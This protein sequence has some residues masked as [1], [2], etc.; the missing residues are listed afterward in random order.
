MAVLK[1]KELSKRFG[2]ITAC[3]RVSFTLETN[4]IVGLVGENGAGKSTLIKLISGVLKKDEGRIL[5][6]EEEVEFRSPRDALRKGISTVYQDFSLVETLTIKDNIQ[7]QTGAPISEIERMLR[8]LE[9][10]L[11]L[12]DEVSEVSE[13]ERQK[14]E[15]LKALLSKPK[16]LLLDEPTHSLRKR[17]IKSLFNYLRRTKKRM[18]VLFI[19]HKL[20]E[21]REIADRALL[22]KNGRIFEAGVEEIDRARPSVSRKK[23][24][25]ELLRVEFEDFNLCLKEGEIVALVNFPPR[26]KMSA[27]SL[28]EKAVI[29]P[30][31]RKNYL[32]MELSVRKNFSIGFK[33]LKGLFLSKIDENALKTEVKEA[34]KEYD[35]KAK[36]DDVIEVLS[37]GNQQ[38]VMLSKALS[39]EFKLFIGYNIFSS[40]DSKSVGKVKRKLLRKVEDGRGI[41][42]FTEDLDEVKDIASRIFIHEKGEITCLA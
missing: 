10:S 41:L 12:N 2:D 33:K 4:E 23:G 39:R 9:F 20:R 29:V 13:N 8:E 6:D 18:G 40:L 19:S 34:I 27:L 24:K 32:F 17:E 22:M 7:L 21:V 42:L 11:S 26:Y 38:K 15:I 16:V 14:A 36:E 1:V 5:V 35:I 31:D 28:L 3:D 30:E 25:R 37:G